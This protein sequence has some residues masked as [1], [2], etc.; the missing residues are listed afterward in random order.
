MTHKN[1]FS[2]RQLA[3]NFQFSNWPALLVISA[4]TL[5]LC[6]YNV[7]GLEVGRDEGV[8]AFAAKTLAFEGRYALK[9]GMDYYNFDRRIAVGPT[10]IAP[11]ALLFKLFGVSLY[12]IRAVPALYFLLFIL[13][14]YFLVKREFSKTTAF[15]T[16]LL[17]LSS[18]WSFW[19]D[20]ALFNPIYRTLTGESAGLFFLALS[21]LLWKRG[22]VSAFV[23]GLAILTK[24]QFALAI[25]PFLLVR[26]AKYGI[27]PNRENPGLEKLKEFLSTGFFLA[28]PLFCWFLV[29]YMLL[30]SE[31]FWSQLS[32]YRNFSDQTCDLSFI[33]IKQNI[34]DKWAELTPPALKIFFTLPA[35]IY[36]WFHTVREKAFRN[37]VKVFMIIFSTIWM[38]WY[39]FSRGYIRYE[40]PGLYFS[41]IFLSLF[42]V[43]CFKGVSFKK[44]TPLLI[45]I[46]SLFTLI[47]G[48]GFYIN[49]REAKVIEPKSAYNM[50][51]YLKAQ[52]SPGNI[53]TGELDY[54]VDLFLDD[55][56]LSLFHAFSGAR[57]KASLDEN[58][59][60][61]TNN[62]YSYIISKDN[63]P[64]FESLLRL[65]DW[66]FVEKFGDLSLYRFVDCGCGN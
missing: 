52:V 35:I 20:I 18:Q 31:S 60:Y 66:R 45:F 28:F 49:Y 33:R 30:V 65:D 37:G 7:G 9:S 55:R 32:S 22:W 25:V 14:F 26:F 59:V 13:A 43:N 6:F 10:I 64:T 16:C 41:L 4:I 57:Q 51:K 5:F 39:L 19:R 17:I 21:L 46:T 1:K 61:P 12:T 23:L 58:F 40:I 54:A 38:V 15:L 62:N 48:F 29:Q 3:D 56:R 42:F 11:T 36:G 47:I 53:L 8:H 2:I 44:D 50:A 63:D 27:L 24:Y 34:I